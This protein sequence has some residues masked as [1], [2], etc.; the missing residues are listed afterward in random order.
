MTAS[1]I[2]APSDLVPPSADLPVDA[3]A[4][5]PLV[6][7]RRKALLLVVLLAAFAILLGLAI[8]YL[9]F[10]QPI[11]LPAPPGQVVMPAYS[12]SIYGASRPMGVTTAPDGSR[13]YV[14]AT[15]G[16][17][18]A[19]VFD[20]Q[21]T[22]LGL[23]LPPTSTGAEHA[24]VYLARHPATGEIYVSDR[25][26]G[27]IFI[28]DADGAYQ[29]KLTVS[30]ASNTFQPLGLA[31][32]ATGNLFVTDVGTVPQ[33]VLEIDSAGKVMRTIG[34]EANLSFPN[35]VA[36]DPS[37]V[38]YVT[39]SN[40]GRLL[41]FGA[42][43]AIVARVGRG[44]GGGNLGLPRG[45]ALDGEG[46][47]YVADASGQQVMVFSAVGSE[48]GDLRSLGSFGSEGVE[49][50][51]FEFPNGVATDSRGRVYVTDSANDRVQVWSY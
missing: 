36:V 9:L 29:R 11:P 18:T 24:P 8:W 48:A 42:D 50:G 5:E 51:Q 12:T 44:V 35:G 41:A 26:T 31:F 13:I 45:V 6:R 28:Y 27:A 14:G 25:S 30:G 38:V 16:D 37:G 2:P 33:R 21:G 23:M 20:P 32:D 1:P 40:N 4:A 17:L 22:E 7:N 46:R 39:D 19:R 3:D 47:V 10:R 49:N 43:G 34:A 15:S